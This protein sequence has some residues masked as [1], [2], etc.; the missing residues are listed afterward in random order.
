MRNFDLLRACGGEL[1]GPQ[2]VGDGEDIASLVTSYVVPDRA[3]S[4][5][6]F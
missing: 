1:E 6:I 3:I 4:V 5:C 2:D